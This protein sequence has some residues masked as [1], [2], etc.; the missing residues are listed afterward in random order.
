MLAG[1]LVLLVGMVL[2]GSLL[3]IGDPKSVHSR[4]PRSGGT[5]VPRR[6]DAA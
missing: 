1:F 3:F 2:L 5:A 6:P 4:G